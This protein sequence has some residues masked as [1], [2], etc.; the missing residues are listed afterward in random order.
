MIS[1]DRSLLQSLHRR[2]AAGLA[3]A[4]LGVIAAPES[5]HAVNQHTL[6]VGTGEFSATAPWDAILRFEGA[7]AINGNRSPDGTLDFGSVGGNFPHMFV[8]RAS[9]D[10]LYV[11]SLFTDQIFVFSNASGLSGTSVPSRII[12]GPLTSLNQPHGLWIDESRDIL[13]VA[14]RLD[15]FGGLPGNVLA[16]DSAST[17]SGGT[18]P[19]RI[20]GGPTTG[21][22]QPFNVFVDET[23]DIL[24]VASANES[25]PG[26]PDPAIVIFDNASTLHGDVPYD[27]KLA[28]SAT[29]FFS[30]LTV[31]N[32]FVD[33]LRDEM[34][35][36]HH[37]SD[38]L[39]FANASTITGN[40]AP[41]RTLK[42]FQS[43]LGLFLLPDEDVLY[44]S[45]AAANLPGCAAGTGPCPGSPPQA[46][47]VFENASTLHGMVASSADRVIYWEPEASTYFPP[48]PLWVH[49]VSVTPALAP[50]GLALLALSLGAAV[51]GLRRLRRAR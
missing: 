32:V 18:P 40:E 35:V 16:W 22:A 43:V 30:H 37:Q 39:V 48:Q 42:G 11:T 45:D 13:Y 41:T 24:Y 50:P 23:N 46:I 9:T 49:S 51:F 15:I 19:D 12:G 7:D 21:M 14:T 26:V 31:H 36:A 6:F 33:T 5:S 25:S 10:E 47:R 4:I 17:A 8:Y 27:R 20:I 3:A 1:G 28:G 29:T 34:Y 44:V 2:F 38:V